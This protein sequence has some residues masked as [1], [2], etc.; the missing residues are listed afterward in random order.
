[1]VFAGGYQWRGDGG[2][3]YRGRCFVSWILYNNPMPRQPRIDIQG[4]LYHVI[5]RGIERTDIF[6][7]ADVYGNF[8]SRLGTSLKKTNGSCMAWC[9]MPN[10]FHLLILRG[11]RQLSELTHGVLAH[12]VLARS[13]GTES[14]D[15][16]LISADYSSIY[17]PRNYPRPA[18]KM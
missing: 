11:T 1:M 9:L 7:D 14:W 2:I 6:R 15:S 16:I 13:L 4:Q 10:H 18:Q 5:A 8:I 17:C 3:G 12:G